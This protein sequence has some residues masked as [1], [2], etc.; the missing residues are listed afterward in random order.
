MDVVKKNNKYKQDSARGA[1]KE[2]V[3]RGWECCEA[4]GEDGE[5]IPWF[6][7][8]AQCVGSVSGHRQLKFYDGKS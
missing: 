2:C 4:G 7:P 3:N 6:S 8:R 1:L 5:L